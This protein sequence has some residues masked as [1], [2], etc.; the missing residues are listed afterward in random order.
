MGVHAMMMQQRSDLN[1]GS[2]PFTLDLVYLVFQMFR[3]L[4][5]R[6]PP[7]P[8]LD[9]DFYGN[10]VAVLKGAAQQHLFVRCQ[11]VG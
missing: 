9:H 11:E 10:G 2:T 8:G 4:N 3:M 1:A 7:L 5:S 6:H